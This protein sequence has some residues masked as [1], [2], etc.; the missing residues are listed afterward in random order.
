MSRGDLTNVLLGALR[1]T[2]AVDNSDQSAWSKAYDEY[3]TGH[4]DIAFRRALGR[5]L[6]A[7]TAGRPVRVLYVGSGPGTYLRSLSLDVPADSFEC[8]SVDRSR[9]TP[10]TARHFRA[11]WETLDP[12]DARPDPADVDHRF[13]VMIVDAEPHG[14]EIHIVDKFLP[15]MAP[16]SLV[17]AKCIGCATTGGGYMGNWLARHLAAGRRLRDYYFPA[18][19]DQ[20][21]VYLVVSRDAPVDLAP[22]VHDAAGMALPRMRP[23]GQPDLPYDM[24]YDDGTKRFEDAV[25]R[26]R[27]LEA[28]GQIGPFENLA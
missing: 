13:D 15:R 3:K 6:A 12:A 16:D 9:D 28:A 8:V 14:R 18:H 25:I 10:G 26:V 4:L 1:D 11:D 7:W 21:D 5:R 24:C 20:R 19:I 2:P 22:R 17:V 27:S 23:T